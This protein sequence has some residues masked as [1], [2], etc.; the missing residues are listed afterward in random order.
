MLENN[1]AQFNVWLSGAT[2]SLYEQECKTSGGR[3]KTGEKDD[4]VFRF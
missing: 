1:K 3:W 2:G 4:S